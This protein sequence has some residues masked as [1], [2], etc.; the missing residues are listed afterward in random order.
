MRLVKRFLNED[1]QPIYQR[2]PELE[3]RH[4]SQRMKG[5]LNTDF[6]VTANHFTT[7]RALNLLRQITKLSDWYSCHVISHSTRIKRGN[8]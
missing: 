2:I 8:S 7:F 4:I 5:R 1:P 3:T 6:K